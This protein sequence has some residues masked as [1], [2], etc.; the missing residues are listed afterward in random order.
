MVLWQQNALLVHQELTSYPLIVLVLLA[1]KMDI[2]L[3]ILTA[4]NA[5]LAA[6]LVWIPL[7]LAVNPAIIQPVI[8]S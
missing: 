6:K 4:L 3:V 1:L 5:I 7:Q 8:F 2:L